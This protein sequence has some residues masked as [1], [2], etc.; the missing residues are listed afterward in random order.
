MRGADLRERLNVNGVELEPLIS[1]ALYWRARR[2]LVIA[3]LHFEKG[4]AFARRGQLLPPYDTGATLGQLE[5]LVDHFDPARLICLGDSLHDPNAE[6]RLSADD[7]QRIKTLTARAEVIWIT[8]NHDPDPPDSLGGIAMPT[9]SDG[10]LLFQHEAS[11]AGPAGEVSGHFHPK[12]VIRTRARR[13]SARCFVSDGRR[14]ILPSF[15]AFTGGLN[16]RNRA[17][18]RH[19]P[20]GF[21]IWLMGRERIHRF[22]RSAAQ[23]GPGE[24]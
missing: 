6:A 11:Q 23:S 4:S 16:V 22:P 24:A 19:F 18:E 15:G 17:I 7:R 3:D 8:G 13:F 5:Q 21:D 12:A 10:A 20:N 14:L 9:L 2:T 1:G